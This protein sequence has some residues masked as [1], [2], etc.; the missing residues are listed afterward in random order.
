MKYIILTLL[1]IILSSCATQI[2]LENS[3]ESWVGSSELDLIDAWGPPTRHYA[4]DDLKYLTWDNR[5]QYV[6]PGGSYDY[7]N[8]YVHNTPAMLENLNCDVTMIIKDK[9]ISSWRYE[10]NNCYD[11]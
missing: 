11:F 4:T 5:T 7:G 9:R 8:G 2:E 3:L 6:I 10:G 1:T